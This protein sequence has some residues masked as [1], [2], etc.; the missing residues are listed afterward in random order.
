MDTMKININ[1]QSEVINAI[2]E[3]EGKSR[4]RLLDYDTVT[5]AAATVENRLE[6]LGIPKRF[7]DKLTFT[8]AT[9]Q[10]SPDGYKTKGTAYCTMAIF[11]RGSKDWFL[12]SVVRTYNFDRITHITIE[13]LRDENIV[14]AIIANN[15]YL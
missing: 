8:V 2:A 11:K 12:T 1:N 14:A 4:T 7:W 3:A 10:I 15:C 5:D 6:S 9:N 13:G